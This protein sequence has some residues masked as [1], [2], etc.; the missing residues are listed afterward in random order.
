MNF[1]NV[2]LAE[3]IK[4]RSVAR[5]AKRAPPTKTVAVKL[6]TKEGVKKNPFFDTLFVV[7]LRLRLM[8]RLRLRFRLRLRLGLGLRLKL[9]L[10]LRLGLGLRLS[11]KLR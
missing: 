5:R 4:K 2:S 6:T 8:L 9:G 11:L 1:A 10:R 3:R 7:K